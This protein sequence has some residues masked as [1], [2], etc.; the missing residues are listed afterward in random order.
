MIDV[1]KSWDKIAALYR[2]RYKI[3]TDEVHF[4]PLCPGEKE[5][6]LIGKLTGKKV[7]DLGCGSGQNAVSLAKMGGDVTAVDFSEKQINECKILSRKH[8]VKINTVISSL[9]DLTDRPINLLYYVAI[10][11]QSTGPLEGLA[12]KDGYMWHNVG[13]IEK[14]GLVALC[15]VAVDEVDALFRQFSCELAL[16]GIKR[17]DLFSSVKREGR[18]VGNDGVVFAV[19]V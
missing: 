1:K 12:G 16:V 18:H 10:E 9:E 6:R 11:S 3:S 5:L 2:K 8:K 14:E 4:G 7:I 13:Y 15:V 17:N 19:V